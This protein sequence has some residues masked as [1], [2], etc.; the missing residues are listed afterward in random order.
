M[1]VPA[2]R[3]PSAIT[4]ASPGLLRQAV[5]ALSHG[6]PRS[7]SERPVTRQN[8]LATLPAQ[9]RGAVRLTLRLSGLDWRLREQSPRPGLPT[10][11][12]RSLG[13]RTWYQLPAPTSPPVDVPN[14]PPVR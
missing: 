4:A 3:R 7:R 6:W 11:E 10:H 8:R 5:D 9:H 1:R 14:L 2:A 13:R 12:Y